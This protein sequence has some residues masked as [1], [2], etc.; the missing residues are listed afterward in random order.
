MTRKIF[1]PK[2]DSPPQPEGHRFQ[3]GK[4]Y[5][6]R[7]GDYEVISID[8]PNMVIRYGDGRTVESLI[9]LQARIWENLQENDSDGLED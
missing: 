3:V 1:H 5:Q 7:D 6:N 4:H 9:T 8:E 2:Q